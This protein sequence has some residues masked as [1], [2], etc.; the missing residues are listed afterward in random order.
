MQPRNLTMMTD[1][2]QLTMMYGYYKHGMD[3]NEGIFDLFFRE[4]KYIEYA[5]MAGTESVIEYINNLH[6]TEEDL[7]Y[8]R[9]LKLFDED[10]LSMLR[11]L[12]FTGEIYGMR[13]GTVVF[14]NEP[15]IR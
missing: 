3:K 11:E 7:D 9:F 8:L 13:E 6:F 15:L 4:K 1:L 2:Y 14:P 12:R 5:V 10:F